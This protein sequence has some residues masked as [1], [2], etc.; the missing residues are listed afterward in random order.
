MVL[1]SATH[2]FYDGEIRGGSSD[3]WDIDEL[4]RHSDRGPGFWDDTA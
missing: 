3:L 1:H 4:L 2:L